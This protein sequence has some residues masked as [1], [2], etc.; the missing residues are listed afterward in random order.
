TILQDQT[1][2]PNVVGIR[3]EGALD[4]NGK[5]LNGYEFIKGYGL[6][7]NEQPAEDIDDRNGGL[8]RYRIILNSR[9][10]GKYYLSVER[11]IGS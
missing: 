10:A 7:K 6:K 8:H 1:L 11:K 3:G 9:T 4:A 2:K 5:W